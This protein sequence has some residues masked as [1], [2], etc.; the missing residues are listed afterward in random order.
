MSEDKAVIKQSEFKGVE[1]RESD[2][3]VENDVTE[4]M[5]EDKEKR[6]LQKIFQ[7]KTKIQSDKK[8]FFVKSTY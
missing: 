2:E 7:N 8:P 1:N 6:R 5:V 3:A 4:F